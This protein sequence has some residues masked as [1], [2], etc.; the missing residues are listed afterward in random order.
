M[1]DKKT[2]FGRAFTL[3]RIFCFFL[4]TVLFLGT[5]SAEARRVDEDKKY[6]VI[7]TM[8]SKFMVYIDWPDLNLSSDDKSVIEICIFGEDPF[9]DKLNKATEL[10]SSRTKLEFNIRK[11]QKLTDISSC[12][13]A[14]LSDGIDN[15]NIFNELNKY[16]VLTITENQ[17][18]PEYRGMIDFLTRKKTVFR[19][20][21]AKAKQQSIKIKSS[22]LKLAQ[23]V[24]K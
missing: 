14:Y 16:P 15:K 3:H 6:T 22:L 19:I 8:I 11:N 2:Y 17:S 13:V 23:E 5:F 7:A 4:L 24:I 12:N 20:N 10:I 21:D 18:D 9:E 1:I